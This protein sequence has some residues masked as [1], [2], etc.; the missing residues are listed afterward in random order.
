MLD[1]E[2][3]DSKLKTMELGKNMPKVRLLLLEG[4]RK[5]IQ[6]VLALQ[7]QIKDFTNP[8]SEFEDDKN[9][10][11][12]LIKEAMHSKEDKHLVGSM[13][14]LNDALC[15]LNT[16]YN[17]DGNLSNSSFAYLNKVLP[18]KKASKMYSNC[19]EIF[20][21][22][23]IIISLGLESRITRM[24]FESIVSKSFTLGARRTF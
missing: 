11:L 14:N 17:S 16:R 21:N 23:K 6:F 3:S 19:L 2:E 24:T 13:Y 4:K 12:Q 15:Y 10:L 7:E 18:P 9:K 8:E 5:Y 1:L 20:H 22:M